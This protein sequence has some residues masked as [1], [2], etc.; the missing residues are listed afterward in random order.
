MRIE[1]F[2]F[3]DYIHTNRIDGC[4]MKG[5]SHVGGKLGSC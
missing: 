4:G 5:F 1:R 2:L 3:V